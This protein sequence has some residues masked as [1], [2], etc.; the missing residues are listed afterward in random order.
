MSV[1]L[2]KWK[3]IRNKLL[4][5]KLFILGALALA[6]VCLPSAAA[7][8]TETATRKSSAEA[9]SAATAG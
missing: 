9:T 5:R 8:T 4:L 7:T 2:E 1:G 6:R 3:K